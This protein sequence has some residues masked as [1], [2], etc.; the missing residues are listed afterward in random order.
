MR[1]S[2]P[3]LKV[4]VRSWLLL[5]SAH[6]PRRWASEARV[7]PMAEISIG[8]SRYRRCSARSVTGITSVS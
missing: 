6:L 5:S 1:P 2:M 3:V 7:Q 8:R 4:T